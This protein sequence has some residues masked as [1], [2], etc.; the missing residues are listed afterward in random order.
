STRMQLTARG[1]RLL[2]AVDSAGGVRQPV[3]K[4]TIQVTSG[5]AAQ[6]LPLQTIIR[7]PRQNVPLRAGDVVTA[8]FQPLSFTALG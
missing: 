7:D 6:T 5:N 8:L 4:I 1:E 3:D 2:D